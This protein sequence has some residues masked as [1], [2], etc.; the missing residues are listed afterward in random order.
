MTQSLLEK[1]LIAERIKQTKMREIMDVKEASAII[2]ALV[3]GYHLAGDQG[4]GGVEP[5]GQVD[6]ELRD[7][8]R[9]SRR[10]R[11]KKRKKGKSV[12]TGGLKRST[13]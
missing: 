13:V 3:Q 5:T 12:Q 10:W 4:D 11:R 8:L 6:Q 7:L 9:V 2:D 1:M